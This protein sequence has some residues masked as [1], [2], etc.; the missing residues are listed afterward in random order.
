MIHY[1]TQ[2]VPL[3]TGVIGDNKINSYDADSIGLNLMKVNISKTFHQIKSERLKI[4]LSLQ[5]MRSIVK[6]HNNMETVID[7]LL[8][9]QRI[10]LHK[11]FNDNLRESLQYE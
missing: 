1:V 9:F 2:Y 4:V 10:S 6:V 3:S 7:P 5:I 11:K 8:F